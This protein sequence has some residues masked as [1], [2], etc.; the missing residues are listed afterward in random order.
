[1]K[2]SYTLI[3]L[4]FSVLYLSFSQDQHSIDSLR[5]VLKTAKADTAKVNTLNALADKFK[6]NNPDQAITFASLAQELA[7][8]LNY[9][10]GIAAAY[11]TIGIASTYHGN[12]EKALKNNYDALKIYDQLLLSA[13]G[14]GKTVSKSKILKQKARAYNNIGNNYMYQ[15]NYP[16]ALKNHAVALKIKEEIGNKNGVASSYHNIGLIYSHLCNYPEALKNYFAGLKI[17][18]EIR[19]KLGI[20]SSFNDIGN[21]YRAQSDYP[22][23]LKNYFAGLKMY[24]E[25]KEKRGIASIYNNLGIV[26]QALGD[27]PKA[28]KNFSAS[29]IIMEELGNKVG[30]ATNYNNIGVTYERQGNHSEALSNYFISLKIQ[31]DIG[32]K[33]GIAKS[34][35]NLGGIYLNQK[36]NDE[37]FKYY[38]KGLA[39]AK[40]IGSLE[41]ITISYFGLAGVDSA[42]G[43]FKMALEHYKMYIITRD[44]MFNK[45]NSKKLVQSKM[46]YEF[47]KKEALAKVEQEKKDA[48]AHQELRTQKIIRNGFM[49]GFVV[50]LLFAGVF[51]RQRNKI[52]K[53]NSALQLAKERA[54]QSEQFEQ[55]FLANMSHEIRTPMNAVMG[56]TSLV[57]DTPLMEKQKFYLEGIKKSGE[58]LLHIINDI[59]DLSKIEAGKMELEKIDFSL[60]DVLGQVRQTL[61]HRAEEKGL[62]LLVNIDSK[63]TDIVIG[64][65]VRL[66]QVLVNLTGNAI[67]FTEKGSVSIE[68]SKENEGIRFSIVDTGI[69]IPEDKLQTV[70]E[71]FSQANAS[72]TRRYGGTGLG[73]NISRQLV[74]LMG[75]NISV[76][77]VEGSGTTFSFRVAFEKGSAERLEQRLT[78]EKQ[79]DGTILDGLTILI[80]DDNEYNRIVAKDTLKSKCYAEV[81]AVGSAKE[82]IDLLRVKKFDVLLLDV[83]MPVMNG[84]EATRFIRTNLEL[85]GKNIPIIALTA[86]AMRT[87][88]DKCKAAGMDSYIPKPFKASQLIIGIAKVLNIELKTGQKGELNSVQKSV[89]KPGVTDLEYLTRFCEGDKVRIGKYIGMFL[90][91]S[92][93]F[94][95]KLNIAVTN[96]NLLEIADQLHGYKTKFIMMGMK[97]AKDLAAEIEMKCRQE[98]NLDSVNLMLLKLIQQVETAVSELKV[99]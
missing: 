68:V 5:S 60:S 55:Q 65:P 57:L 59:L 67:K 38:N 31:E 99:A 83:Q 40:R 85:P 73:L 15:G 33:N 49:G 21:V 87:D 12:Y 89:L 24:E 1:M 6:T 36:K 39:L 45:E 88:L 25:I 20:A 92:P 56:M 29:L 61:G 53:V 50:V 71:S 46:Q 86:S 91:S 93:S 82:A 14:T 27:Y 76:S 10:M 51:F 63:I 32:D 26:Y 43:N 7:I 62:E 98:N 35:N 37:S 78:S 16:E 34:Y 72:D 97:E 94:L 4:L 48:V 9:Q 79:V 30:I 3:V 22:E 66:N 23:A 52:K 41:E 11:L 18:E 47:D 74:E 17:Y 75:G 77:S 19:D 70:F 54:E 58:T 96:G 2:R 42:Q 95:D 81:V 90:A 64:D 69:G 84:F 13:V 28:N 80:V 8:K 44:S